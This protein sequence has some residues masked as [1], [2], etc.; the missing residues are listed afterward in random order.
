[1]YLKVMNLRADMRIPRLKNDDFCISIKRMGFS[2]RSGFSLTNLT[3]EVDLSADSLATRNV[4]VI[5]PNSSLSL[6]DFM[7]ASQGAAFNI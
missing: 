3:G 7:F 2:E 5:L 6:A 4:N 1:M